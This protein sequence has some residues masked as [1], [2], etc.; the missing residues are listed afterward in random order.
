VERARGQDHFRAGRAHRQYNTTANT[1]QAEGLSD[2]HKQR[3]NY[4]V[5]RVIPPGG[6]YFKWPWER[7]HKVSIATQTMNM[8]Q[9][10][11]NP[12]ANMGGTILER[13]PKTS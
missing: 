5:V 1:P 4:P 3:Y 12:D 11:K 13:S 2:E 9:I 10:P 7:I 6:P 8:A